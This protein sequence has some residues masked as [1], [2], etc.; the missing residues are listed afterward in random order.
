MPALRT[1]LHDPQF[2][3][4]AR[5]MVDFGPGIAAWGLVTGVAMAKSGLAPP[6]AVLMA[7]TVYS[8]SAQL[9]SLPLLA[10][11]APMWVV[12]SAA[13]CV[14]LRFVVFSAQWRTHLGHLPRGR[15]LMLGYLLADLN[16]IVFQRAWPGARREAGQVPYVIG[17]IATIW[18]VWQVPSAV[19]IVLAEA[20]PTA[21]GLG[22]AGTLAMLGLTYG[23]LTD[24]S[25]W[26]AAVVAGTAAVAAYAL[27]LKLNIVVAIAAAV[28]AGLLIERADLARQRLRERS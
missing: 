27:P 5:D 9:A 7:L 17:G 14:N 8:G 22:F 28:A 2:R 6:L 11:G 3:R 23:L 18:L 21:W 26:S 24:R 10:S 13:F 15:R 4:G 19:G 20:I 12:W 16:L 25:T 1:L